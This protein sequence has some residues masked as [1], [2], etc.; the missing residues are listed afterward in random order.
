METQFVSNFQTCVFTSY[1]FGEVYSG[2]LF[3]LVLEVS[4]LVDHSW[5]DKRQMLFVMAVAAAVQ[6]LKF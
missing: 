5:Y 6:Q 2:Y 3:V 1:A 4:A